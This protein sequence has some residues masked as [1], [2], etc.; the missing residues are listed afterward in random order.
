MAAPSE[1]RRRA[2][3][4]S[5]APQTKGVFELVLV[6]VVELVGGG[7]DL[8]LVDE[9]DGEVLEDL[10]FDEVADADL[11]HNRDGDGGLDLLD[12]FGVGHAGDA[13][14]S[15]DHGGDALE[16]HDGDGAGLLGDDG[17]VDVHDVHDDAA[18][19]H[20][21]ETGLEAESVG[22]SI[23]SHVVSPDAWCGVRARSRDIKSSSLR[24]TR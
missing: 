20:L 3:P 1:M 24:A 13:A 23:G 5:L 8:G 22:I 10:G 9:V 2:S 16:G 4:R 11:G 17:L 21:G 15:A 14:F 12:H 6:D 7:E 18:F 19:E